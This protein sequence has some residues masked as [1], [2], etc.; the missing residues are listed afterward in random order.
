MQAHAKE[1]SA[2]GSGTAQ[3]PFYGLPAVDYKS[4]KAAIEHRKSE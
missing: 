3:C 1:P 2:E 4:D